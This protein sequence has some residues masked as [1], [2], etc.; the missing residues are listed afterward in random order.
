MQWIQQHTQERDENSRALS[1]ERPRGAPRFVDLNGAPSEE[2]NLCA[3]ADVSEGR[4][5]T[6][7]RTKIAPGRLSSPRMSG[8]ELLTPTPPNAFYSVRARRSKSKCH[9]TMHQD[10]PAYQYDQGRE[11]RFSQ[12]VRNGIAQILN[13]PL[14]LTSSRAS[15]RWKIV[16]KR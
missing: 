1:R 11:T 4:A 15:S 10:S 3:G 8:L 2:I 12:A 16:V 13:L 7:N 6:L 9:R 14:A 5:N